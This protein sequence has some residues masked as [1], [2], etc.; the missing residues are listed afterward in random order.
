MLGSIRLNFRAK[1]VVFDVSKWDTRKKK[2]KKNITTMLHG[3][4]NMAGIV[5]RV[6]IILRWVIKNEVGIVSL[7][8]TEWGRLQ[9]RFASP[10]MKFPLF[11]FIYFFINKTMGTILKKITPPANFIYNYDYCYQRDSTVE[12]WDHKSKL[13]VKNK[14]KTPERENTWPVCLVVESNLASINVLMY[15]RIILFLTAGHSIY[16]FEFWCTG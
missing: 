8:N 16:Y 14:Q 10:R 15:K 1:R 4:W 13:N 6:Y 3:E 11:F 7:C 9:P 5:R 2:K 12:I